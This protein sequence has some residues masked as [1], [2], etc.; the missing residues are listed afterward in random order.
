MALG[1]AATPPLVAKWGLQ[2][3]MTTFLVISAVALTAFLVSTRSHASLTPL[4]APEEARM[5]TLVGNRMLMLLCAQAFLGLGV[6]NGL[7]T[8]LEEMLAPHGMDAEQA[9]LVGGVMIV[10]GIVGSVVIPLA[11]DALRRRK[12][13]L[14]GC[15]AVATV[16]L[17]PLCRT[18][19]YRGALLFAGIL[20]FFFL[21]AFALLLDLSS[22]LVGNARAGAATGLL[23]LA[24]NGGGVGVI[25]AMLALKSVD[26]N[27]TSAVALLVGFL[28][29]TVVLATR[30]REPL[31]TR[32]ATK[33]GL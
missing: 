28:A 12:P 24:G 32:S 10:G 21:P 20:G 4:Q 18:H 14:I 13:F 9:G 7:S 17:Y 31:L 29:L 19:S 27:F 8:F 16:A 1:M 33:D 5:G 26:G 2:G 3:A 6:F 22:Q 30:I 15:S 11:S 25:L 23:M